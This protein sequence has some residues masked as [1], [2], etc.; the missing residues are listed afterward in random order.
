MTKERILELAEMGYIT[1]ISNLDE[2][3]KYSE[4]DLINMGYMTQ[5]STFDGKDET[6]EESKPFESEVIVDVK[7][8][9][10]DAPVVD[11]G[12]EEPQE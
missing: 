2:L 1:H 6:I 10:I 12:E 4:M 5:T 11:E 7:E 8:E 3:L 9:E